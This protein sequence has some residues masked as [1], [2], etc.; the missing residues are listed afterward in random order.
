MNL[1]VSAR[2]L[3][4]L[5]PPFRFH[6]LRTEMTFLILR[7]ENQ[8]HWLRRFRVNHLS[9]VSP[10]TADARSMTDKPDTFGLLFDGLADQIAARVVVRIEAF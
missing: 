1:S 5:S 9:A 2:Q 3:K 4:R 6:A 8:T 10:L 7:A